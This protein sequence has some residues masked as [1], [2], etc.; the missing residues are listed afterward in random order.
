[1]RA[2]IARRWRPS[3]KLWKTFA[4]TTARVCA[5]L[6]VGAVAS[7]RSRF[8]FAGNTPDTLARSSSCVTPRRLAEG[9]ITGA[10]CT[11]PTAV[12][13]SRVATSEVTSVVP[14]AGR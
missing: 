5:S 4:T 9:A 6:A 10:A 14:P 12:C 2:S 11:S 8:E 13:R 1:M 3:R 7:I